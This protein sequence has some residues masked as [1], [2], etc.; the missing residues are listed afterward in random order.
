MRW[1]VESARLL[2]FLNPTE[3]ALVSNALLVKQRLSSRIGH[4]AAAPQLF[5]VSMSKRRE[6]KLNGS[7]WRGANLNR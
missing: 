1:E 4:G 7:W 6:G 2:A 5:T 3:L